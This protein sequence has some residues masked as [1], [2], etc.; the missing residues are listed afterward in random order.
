MRNVDNAG[1][2]ESR[3]EKKIMESGSAYFVHRDADPLGIFWMEERKLLAIAAV[4]KGAGDT[5]MHTMMSLF[6]EEQIHLEV[7]STNERAIRL[8]ERFGFIRTAELSRWYCVG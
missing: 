8:Y 5:V 1:T 3:D 4:R 6:P 2:L 7:A